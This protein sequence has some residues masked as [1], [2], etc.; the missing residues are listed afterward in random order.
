MKVIDDYIDR[1]K[2]NYALLINGDWGN[3]KTYFL[4]NSI[5]PHLEKIKKKPIYIS[6]NG[7]N[8]VDEVSKQIYFSISFLSKDVFKKFRESKTAKYGTEIIKQAHNIVSMSGISGSADH[9]VDYQELID[10]NNDN[11]VLCFDDLERC[12][13]DLVEILGYINN[14][15]EHDNVKTI[16]VGNEKEIKDIGIDQNKELKVL[17]SILSMGIQQKHE[18]SEIKSQYNSLFFELKQ[19][20]L[21]KEKLV[22]QTITFE[23]DYTSIIGEMINEYKDVD[24]DYY[25]YLQNNKDLITSI[26]NTSSRHNLRI[27]KHAMSDFFKIFSTLKCL[28]ASPLFER[29][30]DGYF[31][32]ALILT[33]EYREANISSLLLTE[34]LSRKITTSFIHICID[35]NDD[36]FVFYSKY[37]SAFNNKIECYESQYICN[38]IVTSMLEDKNLLNEAIHRIAEWDAQNTQREMKPSAL[39]KLDNFLDLEN[40]EFNESFAEVITNVKDGCYDLRRYPRIFNLLE[41]F[42]NSN[43]VSDITIDDLIK[44]F[45]VG[46]NKTDFNPN[47]IDQYSHRFHFS[48]SSENLK[49]I[50]IIVEE[51]ISS[52]LTKSTSD[53]IDNLLN[54]LPDDVSAF[55]EQ[56]LKH[57]EEPSLKPIL[58]YVDIPRFYQK[59]KQVNNSELEHIRSLFHSV[60]ESRNI[61]LYFKADYNNMIKLK[62]C[63]KADLN[64]QS[65]VRKLQYNY[66][67]DNLEKYS[68]LIS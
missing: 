46:I 40:D 14:F 28:K 36:E 39:D 21:I 16:I 30:I 15:V 4:R 5:I 23:P 64:N 19:F 45:L 20:D 61:H 37:F 8:S 49:K 3:G 10:F 68:N 34:R 2:T 43:L 44:I 22:G 58:Q 59:L 63:F 55:T 11:M 13:I 35:K 54:H 52:K 1:P 48:K 47:T 41:F 56:Y 17:A 53:E 24:H 32:P 38:Y 29:L 12:K 25:D 18:V 60:Y 27:I 9:K 31:V 6:L 67:I 66:F 7:L 51:K 50:K 33:I 57:V 62:E 65:G 26:H 42:I